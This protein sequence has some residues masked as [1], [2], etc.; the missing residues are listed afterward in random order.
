MLPRGL[1]PDEVAGLGYTAF[2]GGV[3]SDSKAQAQG[4]YPYS[5][6][7][8]CFLAR[9]PENRKL[10]PS[11]WGKQ[12]ISRWWLVLQ[13]GVVLSGLLVLLFRKKQVL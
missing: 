3:G 9:T 6:M 7:A 12:P 5:L 1:R 13:N 8:H 2:K 4:H 11:R 10:E